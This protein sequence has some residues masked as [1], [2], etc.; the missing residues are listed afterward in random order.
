MI[1]PFPPREITPA[2]L[3]SSSQRVELYHPKGG[4]AMAQFESPIYVLELRYRSNCAK[5][6]SAQ[7]GKEIDILVRPIGDPM[8]KPI[9]AKGTRSQDG[10]SFSVVVTRGDGAQQSYPLT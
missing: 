8:A 6:E 1:P 4:H 3:Q 10:A 7:P 5:I 2:N 9:A